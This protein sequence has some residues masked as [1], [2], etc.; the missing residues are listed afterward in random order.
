MSG[1]ARRNL[2]CLLVAALAVIGLVVSLV[3][4]LHSHSSP[5]QGNGSLATQVQEQSEFSQGWILLWL[6]VGCIGVIVVA[7]S[8]MIKRHRR[9]QHRL[10]IREPT[11]E[12]IDY[13]FLH[14]PGR[15]K[16]PRMRASLLEQM[17]IG[18]DIEPSRTSDIPEYHP[19]H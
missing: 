13:T 1:F 2:D 11:R 7:V 10:H 5:L 18:G 14:P 8:K 15:P 4:L 19:R 16:A 3:V 9:E 12:G 6:A 17:E